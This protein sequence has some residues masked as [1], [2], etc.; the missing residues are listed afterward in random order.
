[1]F[2]SRAI[3]HILYGNCEESFNWTIVCA[4]NN[5]N[6]C[7]RRTSKQ[8]KNVYDQIVANKFHDYYYCCQFQQENSSLIGLGK[9]CRLYYPEE[10]KTRPTEPGICADS[11][12][13]FE[14]F[15]KQLNEIVNHQTY[16]NWIGSHAQSYTCEQIFFACFFKADGVRVR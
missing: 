9:Q 10:L 14:S 5:H 2:S 13:Q 7:E 12:W 4:S 15:D 11:S 1:M 8:I 6:N 16:I 3:L